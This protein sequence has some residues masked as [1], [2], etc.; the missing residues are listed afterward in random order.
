MR[1]PRWVGILGVGGS[2]QGPE[3]EG[4]QNQIAP[5]SPTRYSIHLH[6]HLRLLASMTVKSS[7]SPRYAPYDPS[8]PKPWRALVDGRNGNL[9]FW[10]PLTKVTQYERPSA[11]EPE[12]VPYT[13][14]SFFFFFFFYTVCPIIYHNDA[15]SHPFFSI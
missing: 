11:S 10:N 1:V 15:S 8:L 12:V 14:S 13:L 4:L 5:L 6:L 3:Q 2:T 7:D 9:Y